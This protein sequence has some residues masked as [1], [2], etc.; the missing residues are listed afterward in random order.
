MDY[1]VKPTDIHINVQGNVGKIPDFDPRIGSH[2]WMLTAIYKWIP[3]PLDEQIMLDH[4][5]LL[6]IIG[7]GCFYC[8]E[9]Y[10]KR[11]AKRR[12]KGDC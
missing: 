5:N 4:E 9:L 6:E 3:K 2:L 7:P 10:D 11:I 1:E 12:C 8:G